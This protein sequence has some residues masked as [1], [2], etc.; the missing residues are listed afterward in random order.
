MYVGITNPQ[1]RG[2][3]SQ[4]SWCMRN[5]HLYVSGKRPM[6]MALQTTTPLWLINWT[7]TQCFSRFEQYICFS[8]AECP[9]SESE[10][11]NVMLYSGLRLASGLRLPVRSCIVTTNL[12]TTVLDSLILTRI[13]SFNTSA[14]K[15]SNPSARKTNAYSSTTVN[16]VTADDLVTVTRWLFRLLN[17]SLLCLPPFELLVMKNKTDVG[18]PI[19]PR[20][21]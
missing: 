17:K 2:K 21:P 16:S 9:H 1:W 5:P 20:P 15:F 19:N 14:T 18:T 3:R 4:H 6:P 10:I 8:S 7:S 12:S 13:S 11:G